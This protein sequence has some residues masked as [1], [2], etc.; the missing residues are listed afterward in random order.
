MSIEIMNIKRVWQIFIG[1]LEKSVFSLEL[2]EL[3][4]AFQKSCPEIINLFV[5]EGTAF[6][7]HQVVEFV[8]FS[9]SLL[10]ARDNSLPV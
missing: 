2:G 3:F 8:H 7:F 5:L 10:L 1:G 6:L 4:C 9:S